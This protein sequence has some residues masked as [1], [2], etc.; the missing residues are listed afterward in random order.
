MAN[1]ATVAVQS[2]HKN[3]IKTSRSDRVYY[4]IN[5]I[6]LGIFFLIIL[7]PLINVVACS[8]S[9]SFAVNSGQVFLWPVKFTLDGYKGVFT[10]PGIW[11][12]YGN[13]F[14]YTIFGTA[15]NL[16]MTLIAAYPLARRNLPGK[17][18]VVA[19][20][21]FTMLFSGGMIPG[22]LLIRDLHMINSVWSIVLPGAISVYNMIIARTFIQNI[23][24]DLEEAAKIDGCSDFRYFVSIVLPL[25]KAVISVLMLYYAVGH[26]NDYMSALLY[27][28]SDKKFPLQLM[29]RGLLTRAEMAQPDGMTEEQYQAMKNMADLLR[30]SLIIVSSVPVLVIYPFAKK[31]FMKGVMIGAVKG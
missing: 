31:Y 12:A 9:D 19:L 2:K 10:Y 1:A 14:Y 20:F 26:W 18:V 3:R 17:G 28:N 6:L 5:N 23:P 8:F 27:M 24:V 11:R 15:I 16:F 29:I 22:Y 21:M 7:I 25:S 4:L 30:Y 13:S